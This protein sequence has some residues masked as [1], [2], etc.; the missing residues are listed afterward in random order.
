MSF[1]LLCTACGAPSGPAVGV[2]PFCK[3]VQSSQKGEE[4]P[5]LKRIRQLFE[6]GYLEDALIN[7]ASAE[8]EN[9][10]LASDLGFLLTYAKIL[11]EAEGPSSKIRSLL[12][13]ASLLKPDMP[14]ISEYLELIEAKSRLNREPN[15]FGEQ[16][17]RRILGHA[18]KNAH[19]LF[20]LAS[21]LFWVESKPDEAVPLLQKCVDYR[22]TF[23][24][25]WAC[26]AAIHAK[27]GD[28]APAQQALHKCLA[29]EKNPAMYA[30]FEKLLTQTI[31][32]AA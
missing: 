30:Y 13:K 14:E 22:P 15:D 6:D 11:L 23:L 29:L 31:A 18:P 12:T 32:R 8:K 3:A 27:R 16:N 24:R 4:N 5:T 7:A 26:L 1:S 28:V 21:H 10:K 20:T 9:A 19:V 25:A 17:L 2:C